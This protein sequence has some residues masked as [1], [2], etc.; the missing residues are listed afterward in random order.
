[1]PPKYIRP[2]TPAD[3]QGILI[4]YHSAVHISA[5]ADYP[6]EVLKLWSPP[7][8][9][10]RIKTKTARLQQTLN[11]SI[12]SYV[13]VSDSNHVI[14]VGELVP[15]KTLGALYVAANFSRIGVASALL[16]V[17]EEHAHKIGMTELSM[18]STL[19]AANFYLKHGFSISEYTTHA[20][21][22]SV[23]MRCISM[24]KLLAPASPTP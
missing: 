21:S 24:R 6:P 23:S 5:A 3:A 19:T 17:L 7:V 18:E 14:A 16:R 8:D 10:H 9:A 4:A 20:L 12:I 13:A 1:M 2:T 15:P 22:D 11:S